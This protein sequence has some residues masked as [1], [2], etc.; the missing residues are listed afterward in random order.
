M[1]PFALLLASAILLIAVLVAN[2]DSQRVVLAL[3]ICLTAAT[4]V[5]ALLLANFIRERRRTE[6]HAQA[7]FDDNVQDFQHMA[8]NIQEIFWMMD[9]KTKKATFVN[10]AYE[11]ITGRSCESLMDEPS[12]Y[13]KVIH[14]EDRVRV[15]SKLA[16]EVCRPWR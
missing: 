8:D 11:T 4:L 7:V 12:S 3:R 16:Q 10:P 2:F 9:P 13:E 1:A 14:P 15:L 5:F 6:K